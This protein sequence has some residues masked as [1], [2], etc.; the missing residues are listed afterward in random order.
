VG[1]YLDIEPD[2]RKPEKF[3]LEL[4]RSHNELSTRRFLKK[5]RAAPPLAEDAESI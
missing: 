2:P 1:Q 4:I 5:A 3:L